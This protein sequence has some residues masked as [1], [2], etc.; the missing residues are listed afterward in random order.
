M[1]AIND[2]DYVEAITTYSGDRYTQHSTPVRDGREGF[3]EFFAN[4][5]ERN[6]DRDHR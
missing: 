6:P 4:F 1:R 3:I 5:V 2:G